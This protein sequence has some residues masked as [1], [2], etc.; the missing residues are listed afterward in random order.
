MTTSEEKEPRV[1]YR[2]TGFYVGVAGIVVSGFALLALAAQNTGDVTID[3]LGWELTM[4]L[5]VVAIGAALIAVV[6]DEAVGLV[7]RRHRR[8]V[9]AERRELKELRA[10]VKA[11]EAGRPSDREVD[12]K[13]DTNGGELRYEAAPDAEEADDPASGNGSR[14]EPSS[15]DSG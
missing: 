8:R 2:G 5:F 4:P 9:L 12:E 14:R 13:G 11:Y 7:W 3:F 15:V 1:E 6:L 10:A